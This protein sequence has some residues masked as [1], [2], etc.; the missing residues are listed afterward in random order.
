MTKG[1]FSMN[2]D[3]SLLAYPDFCPKCLKSPANDSV[4]EKSKSRTIA[5]YFVARKE[6]WLEVEVP[7]CASCARAVDTDLGIAIVS[8]VIL[9]LPVALGLWRVIGIDEEI[10]KYVLGPFIAIFLYGASIELPIFLW[11]HFRN[12]GVVVGSYDSKSLALKIRDLKYFRAFQER[13]PVV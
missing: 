13:N 1:W 3:R 7:Y 9:G 11:F 10:G 2:V 8:I 12:R 6:Q 4:L 5:W